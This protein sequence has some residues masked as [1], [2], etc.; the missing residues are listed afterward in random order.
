MEGEKPA[1]NCTHPVAHFYTKE[2][3][4]CARNGRLR[5]LKMS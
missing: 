1:G 2:A 5:N 4:V 3:L